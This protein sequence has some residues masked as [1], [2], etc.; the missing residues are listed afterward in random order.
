MKIEVYFIL[1]VILTTN[2]NIAHSQSETSDDIDY[3]IA[4][5]KVYII[6]QIKKD[7][8]QYNVNDTS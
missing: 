8:S 1:F 4:I 7:Y 6:P 3:G 5:S 2:V